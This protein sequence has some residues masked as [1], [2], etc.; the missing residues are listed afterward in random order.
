MEFDRLFHLLFYSILYYFQN[1]K[2]K[3]YKNYYGHIKHILIIHNSYQISRLFVINFCY[4]KAVE[5]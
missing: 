4:D 1:H 2:K 3:H 5:S